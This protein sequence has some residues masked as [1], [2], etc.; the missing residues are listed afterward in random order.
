MDQAATT[1]SGEAEG[2]V[3]QLRD[4]LLRRANDYAR[5]TKLELGTVSDRCAG[6]GK[7][8]FAVQRGENFTVSRYQRAMDWLDENWPA[9]ASAA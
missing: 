9:E 5:L 8:L 6:D 2:L 3:T 1:V 7:F 4:S